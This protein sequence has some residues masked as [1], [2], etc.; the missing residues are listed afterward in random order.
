MKNLLSPI[1]VKFESVV[2]KVIKQFKVVLTIPSY[3]NVFH[4]KNKKKLTCW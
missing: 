3:P 4:A 1:I 2:T